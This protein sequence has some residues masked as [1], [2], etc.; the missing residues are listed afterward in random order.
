M[1]IDVDSLGLAELIRLREHLAEVLAERYEST[2]AVA[3]PAG[4]E[5]RRHASVDQA[6]DELVAAEGAAALHFGRVLSDGAMLI[7]PAVELCRQLAAAT[8]P[9][10]LRLTRP[11]YVE[12]SSR[13]RL[14]CRPGPPVTMAASPLPMEILVVDRR[15]V[16]TP[17]E[18]AADGGDGRDADL[19]TIA[20]PQAKK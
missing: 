17:G 20:A 1:T 9:G 10:E 19:A 14:R 15:P 12:L 2:A 8:P 4:G 7:G 16:A 13:N 11:A 18:G 6:F 5:V 3:A